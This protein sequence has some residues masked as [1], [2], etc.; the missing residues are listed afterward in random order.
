MIP[1]FFLEAD[2]WESAGTFNPAVIPGN[3]RFVM[4][5]RDQDKLGTSR[6]GYADSTDGIHFTRAS[7]PVLSPEAVYEKDGGVE[8]PRRVKFGGHLLSDLTGY[9]TK[10]APLC[11]AT[12][13]DLLHWERPGVILPAYKGKWNVGWTKAGAIV[14]E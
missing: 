3:G 12:S 8:D 14:P 7:P 6:L 13:K 10:D 11:R 9:H 1:S 5:Y 2:S 4:L